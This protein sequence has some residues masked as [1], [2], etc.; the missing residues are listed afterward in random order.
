MM[1][2][3]RHHGQQCCMKR[4]KN[5]ALDQGVKSFSASF[6]VH[7]YFRMAP[8]QVVQQPQV[9]VS[10]EGEMRYCERSVYFVLFVKPQGADFHE[11]PTLCD[12]WG[13]TKDLLYGKDL[14]HFCC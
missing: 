3:C 13:E 4:C 9:P 6:L 1:T 10:G 12:K 7:H 2:H 5:K 8:T 14:S 11:S